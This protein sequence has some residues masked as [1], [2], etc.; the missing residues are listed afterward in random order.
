M[1]NYY[2][3]T[4]TNY[5][6]VKDAEAFTRELEKYPV[7][8]I[9]EE[10]PDRTLYGFLDDDDNGGGEICYNYEDI[11]WS[12]FF[13]RHLEND[14][15]AIIMSAGSEKYRYISGYATAYNSAGNEI[16]LE[17][18]DIYKLAEN[19]LGNNVTRAEY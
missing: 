7:K 5:F 2:G 8:I 6:A 12:E 4:R 13:A 14:W 15:V 18:N 17:L 19:H 11:V 10:T 16:H 3:Q 1:A 9:T